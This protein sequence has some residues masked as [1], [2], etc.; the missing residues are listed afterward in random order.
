[1]FVFSVI[2]KL[3]LF[4]YFVKANYNQTDSAFKHS[5]VY[6]DIKWFCKY[7]TCFFLTRMTCWLYRFSLSLTNTKIARWN[8]SIT[9]Y[10]KSS[11]H[12]QWMMYEGWTKEGNQGTPTIPILA[13]PRSFAVSYFLQIVG[14]SCSSTFIT[15]LIVRINTISFFTYHQSR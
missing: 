1:M 15:F 7:N 11:Y 10:F 13:S 8:S 5:W 9:S 6:L 14:Q 4:F 3:I 2:S 12:H